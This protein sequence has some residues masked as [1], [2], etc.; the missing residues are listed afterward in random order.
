NLAEAGLEEE[1]LGR[2]R[3]A[4]DS[5]NVLYAIF[6]EDRRN[7]YLPLV[8]NQN[9]RVYLEKNIPELFTND[10]I[11]WYLYKLPGDIDVDDNQ[12]SGSKLVVDPDSGRKEEPIVVTYNEI[13]PKLQELAGI[14]VQDDE[15]SDGFD[16]EVVSMNT[17][18]M[19]AY[20]KQ[21]E[22]DE[23]E[24]DDLNLRSEER[25]VGKECKSRMLNNK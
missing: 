21:K 3:S 8:L 15:L 24:S 4:L 19:Q 18:E 14:Y 23:A 13:A 20:E 1:T 12:R 22:E 5:D 16:S 11:N 25:S 17:E 10:Y 2:L 6:P 7:G 9:T